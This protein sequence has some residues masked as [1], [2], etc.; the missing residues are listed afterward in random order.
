MLALTLLVLPMTAGALP[1]QQESAAARPGKARW[2]IQVTM[3]LLVMAFISSLS[4]IHYKV[5]QAQ[6][7]LI[8]PL[9]NWLLGSLENW[10]QPP[11]LSNLSVPVLYFVLPVALLLLLGA[12]WREIGFGRGYRSWAV[13]VLFSVPIVL[14]LVLKLVSGEKSLLILL[15]LLIQNTL[16]NGFFEEFLFR[17][18]LM[19]RLNLLLGRSWGVVLSTLLFGLFHASAYTAS[20]HGDLLA[21]M[22]LG[23]VNPVVF[24]LCF[25][26]IVLRTRNLFAASVIHA[27]VDTCGYFVFS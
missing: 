25:A 13:I 2:G 23:M 3:L 21:G 4:L 7:P 11:T 5:I 19:S 20:F 12:R 9:A 26:I 27:L 17:G 15:F 6:I 24:G 10:G 22:A 14:L 1:A 16:R 18:A 8:T